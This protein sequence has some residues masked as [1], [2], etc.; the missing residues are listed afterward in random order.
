[1]CNMYN[2]GA[3][4]RVFSIALRQISQERAH[5]NAARPMLQTHLPSM[6]RNTTTQIVDD[7]IG[8]FFF[9]D[10]P[11]LLIWNWRTGEKVVV[12]YPSLHGCHDGGGMT[13]M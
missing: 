9:T 12:R 4:G 11:G 1:M 3:S 8:S 13:S 7:V 6:A 10:A 5:P 2:S